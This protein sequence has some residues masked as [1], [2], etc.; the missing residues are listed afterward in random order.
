MWSKVLNKGTG[1]A[2][3]ADFGSSRSVPVEFLV[4]V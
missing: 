4:R 3:E 1:G 2:V